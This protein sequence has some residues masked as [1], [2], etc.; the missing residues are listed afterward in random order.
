MGKKSSSFPKRKK[1]TV[2]KRILSKA[3]K[4]SKKGV[5]SAKKF[6]KK[7]E[8]GKKALKYGP[9]AVKAGLGVGGL[10]ASAMTGNPM[11]LALTG[12]AGAIVDEGAS[13]LREHFSRR[14]TGTSAGA[15]AV[16]SMPT[17]ADVGA[18][19]AAPLLPADHFPRLKKASISKQGYQRRRGR[20]MGGR[21]S[22]EV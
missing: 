16:A 21:A 14:N 7:N 3:K 19:A 10:A 18:S 9:G 2:G 13:A 1:Q 15:S 17:G 5:R 20:L 4:T 12:A 11:P 22:H 8:L 6:A